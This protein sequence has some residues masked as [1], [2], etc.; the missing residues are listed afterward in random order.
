MR[1][2]ASLIILLLISAATAEAQGN[3]S[4]VFNIIRTEGRTL[5]PSSRTRMFAIL[6]TI[7][8]ALRDPDFYVR[9][10][11]IA[12][13]IRIGKPAAAAI[14]LLQEIRNAPVSDQYGDS[15]RANAESAIRIL[16]EPPANR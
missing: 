12:A 9:Q 13:V 15:L 14:P 4:D 5:T 1:R 2:M 7:I 3:L 10:E 11:A 16:S 6:E 8:D